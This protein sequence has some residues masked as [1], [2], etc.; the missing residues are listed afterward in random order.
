MS[1]TAQ[2]ERK[3]EVSVV[4]TPADRTWPTARPAPAGDGDIDGVD[5]SP[6]PSWS[7]SR[8]VAWSYETR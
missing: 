3:R 6:S 4:A 8:R 2:A 1:P 5:G 7:C